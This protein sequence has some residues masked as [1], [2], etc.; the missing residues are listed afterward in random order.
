M[1]L[2]PKLT[3]DQARRDHRRMLRFLAFN[4]ALGMTLGI[5]VTAALLYFDVAGIGARIS[6]ASEPV[7]PLL[8]IGFPMALIFGGA[9]TATAV[10]TLPYERLFAPEPKRPDDET[11]D[12]A[13]DPPG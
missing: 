4:A 1:T 13:G 7:L 3:P 6:R 5:L 2:K 9:V 10:W 11:L 8:L 12:E